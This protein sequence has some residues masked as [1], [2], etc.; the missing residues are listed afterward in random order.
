MLDSMRVAVVTLL[1]LLCIGCGGGSSSKTSTPTSA[2]TGTYAGSLNFSGCPSANPCGGD[3]I[4]LTI[5][6]PYNT[7]EFSSAMSLSGIDSTTREPVTGNGDTLDISPAGPGPG[8]SGANAVLDTSLAQ[9]FSVVANGSSNSNT[10]V[11]MQT[12]LVYYC[13]GPVNS[14]TATCGGNGAYLGTLI[15][16]Q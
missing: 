10:P 14:Q 4:N 8:S 1:I 9:P 15:R 5:A 16:Q 2:W 7:P 12:L 3:S 11:L 6:Q 13:A